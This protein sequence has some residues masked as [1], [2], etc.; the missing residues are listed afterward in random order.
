MRVAAYVRSRVIVHV[1]GAP[2][3][4]ILDQDTQ[5]QSQIDHIKAWAD[6]NGHQVV[7]VYKDPGVSAADVDRPVF[8]KMIRDAE[9]S[10]H[11]FDVVAVHDWSR[12]NR[13]ARQF[14]P[15]EGRLAKAKVQLISVANPPQDLEER[16]KLLRLIQ[17][18]IEQYPKW[19]AKKRRLHRKE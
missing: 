12:L 14:A 15:H 4:S 6:Q 7:K 19:E 3:N 2:A 11:P 5:M 17:E 1:E 16:A 8:Q 13:G 10:D 9:A 18:I